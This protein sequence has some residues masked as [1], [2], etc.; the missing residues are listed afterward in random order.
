MT[1]DS[2][3]SLQ[4]EVL[5]WVDDGSLAGGKVRNFIALAEAEARDQLLIGRAEMRSTAV[6]SSE[7]SALPVDLG[8]IVALRIE[9]SPVLPLRFVDAEAFTAA[10]SAHP[11]TGRPRIYTV[12]GEELRF[13]P[14]PDGDYAVELVYRR[15]LP[16]LSDAAPSNW[17]LAR[18][19]QA[20]LNGA[21]KYA[22]IFLVEDGRA[23]AFDALFKQALDA[24]READARRR[25]G[26]RPG[27]FFRALA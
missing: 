3:S 25:T 5:D 16:A 8:E 1:L 27:M 9:T 17:L 15:D 11:L 13:A 10:A 23:E 12:V 21:L 7:M 14:S 22:S 6:V 26:P 24:I 18:Y 4:Q 20:Y 19:P 2:Y